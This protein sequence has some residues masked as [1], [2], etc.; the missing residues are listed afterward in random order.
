M[1]LPRCSSV[2]ECTA[3]VFFFSRLLICHS[4]LCSQQVSFLL[5]ILFFD[6]LMC[7]LGTSV[8]IQQANTVL[9]QCTVVMFLFYLTFTYG[10]LAS[11]LSIHY[12]RYK[13]HYDRY[14]STVCFYCV[15]LR[16]LTFKIATVLI[17]EYATIL[18]ISPSRPTREKALDRACS[19]FISSNTHN[20]ANRLFLL[21]TIPYSTQQLTEF[22][23]EHRLR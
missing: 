5:H 21:S 13:S 6:V 23:L 17:L 15:C 4:S 16:I 9:L 20:A 1:F 19:Q 22:L 12:Q 18:Y 3:T 2:C 8:H 11:S 10:R 14:V 7:C